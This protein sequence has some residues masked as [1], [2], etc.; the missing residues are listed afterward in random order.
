MIGELNSGLILILGALPVPLLPGRLRSAYMLALPPLAFLHLLGLPEGVFGQITLFDLKLATLRVDALSR[1]FAYA[2]L[3]AMLLGMIYA[4]HVKDTIQHVAGL[5]YGGS[6]LGAVFAGDLVTLFLFWEL[7]S[8]ASV[9]L[10]WASRTRRA[11]RAGMPEDQWRF[12]QSQRRHT[13]RRD[14]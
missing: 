8:V 2:F 14:L 5:V 4:L 12:D 9:F 6:A 10:I 1:F 11:Y 7:I 3:L 13:Q